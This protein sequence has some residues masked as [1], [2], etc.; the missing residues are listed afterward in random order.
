[1]RPSFNLA[2]FEKDRDRLLDEEKARQALAHQEK[3]RRKAIL[4][5]MVMRNKELGLEAEPIQVPRP[6]DFDSLEHDDELAYLGKRYR[7]TLASVPRKQPE[8]QAYQVVAQPKPR[9][10]DDAEE[11]GPGDPAEPPAREASPLDLLSQKMLSKQ[12]NSGY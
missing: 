2:T 10:Q 11:A 4:E 1:M 7:E 8:K 3:Q 12:K 6:D 9:D 5:K